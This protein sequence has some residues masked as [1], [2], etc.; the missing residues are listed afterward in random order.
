LLFVGGLCFTTYT[1]SSNASIQ[2]GTPDHLRGRILGIYFYAWTAPLPLASP[3]IGW[4]CAAGGTQL[5][6]VV[7]GIVPA[8]GAPAR[9]RALPPAP[10]GRRRRK[11]APEPTAVVSPV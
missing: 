2:L 9:A 10:P 3:F 4:L 11:R 7:G 5:A 8:A 1:A 6:L